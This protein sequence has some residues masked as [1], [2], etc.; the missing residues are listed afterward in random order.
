[1]EK[2]S[3]RQLASLATVS[4]RTLHHYDKIGLLKPSLRAESGYRYYGRAELFRL[5]QILLYRELDFPLARIMQLLDEE[6]FDLVKALEEQHSELKKQKARLSLLLLTIEKTMNH[7]KTK[8]NN[9]NYEELYK[10]FS[11]EQAEAYRKEAS[12]RWGVKT[13]EDSHQRLMSMDKKD[14]EALKQK[15]EDLNA[16]LV[17]IMHLSPSDKQVQTLIE[18]HYAMTGRYFE[19]TPEIY[20]NLG[21]MYVEDERFKAYYDRYDK[22]L[23]AFLRDAI[24]AFCEDK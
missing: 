10:G 12:A 8:N 4:V 22:G 5:Q 16:A 17:K 20:R 2:F 14:W 21:R 9:M 18:E 6:G 1:M 15:G 19:V 7:L 11:K 24:H 13:I 23:A 3:V